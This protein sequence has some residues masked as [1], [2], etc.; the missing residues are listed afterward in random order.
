MGE[1][2]RAI[3]SLVQ[4]MLRLCTLHSIGARYTFFGKKSRKTKRHRKEQ[5]QR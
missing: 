1:G 3:T 4:M 5:E 2:E